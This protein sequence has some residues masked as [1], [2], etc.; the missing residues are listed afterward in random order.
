MSYLRDIGDMLIRMN[1][2]HNEK[3]QSF[4]TMP[5]KDLWDKREPGGRRSGLIGETVELHREILPHLLTGQPLTP[6]EVKRALDECYDVAISAFL[7][8]GWLRQHLAYI[9]TPAP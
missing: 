9:T 2:K 4:L 7:I 8:A 3:G 6:E 1:G 5:L